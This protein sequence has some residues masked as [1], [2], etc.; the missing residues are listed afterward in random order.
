MSYEVI[1]SRPAER[2]VKNLPRNVLNRVLPVLRFLAD[3]PRPTG[4]VAVAE[5]PG[6][7]R[8]RIGD[9]RIVYAVRDNILIV[10][11]LAIADRSEVYS[12]KEIAR[13]R[14]TLKQWRKG[15]AP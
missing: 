3:D 4:A 14:Q 11:V 15:H 2:D 13:M 1:L 12:Q 10:L 7:Y 6:A 5:I 9:S 8:V